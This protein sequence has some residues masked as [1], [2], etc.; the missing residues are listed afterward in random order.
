MRGSHCIRSILKLI[1]MCVRRGKGGGG[2]G[3]GIMLT[4]DHRS[5]QRQIVFSTRCLLFQICMLR[6][7]IKYL[8]LKT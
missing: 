3:Y 2:V 1:H 8:S 7:M 6:A 4:F 5:R